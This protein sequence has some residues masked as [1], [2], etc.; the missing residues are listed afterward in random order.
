MTDPP[1]SIMRCAPPGV[2]VPGRRAGAGAWTTGE[3]A[4]AVRATVSPSRYPARGRPAAGAVP[5]SDAGRVP[6]R[7]APWLGA[8]CQ[9]RPR[10]VPR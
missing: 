5:S 1:V 6:A 3:R 9:A 10:A 7:I 2:P 4:V 8:G